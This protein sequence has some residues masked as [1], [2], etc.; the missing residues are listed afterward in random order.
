MK[1]IS[2]SV[3]RHVND[4]HVLMSADEGV[5]GEQLEIGSCPGCDHSIINRTR[6]LI[7]LLFA[8]TSVS[9]ADLA[10]IRILAPG[11]TIARA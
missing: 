11:E 6:P 10:K 7:L 8:A 1:V 9:A 5:F 4:S 3:Q 2:S